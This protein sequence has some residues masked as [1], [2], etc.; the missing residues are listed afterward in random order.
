MADI[1]LLV[2]RQVTDL[3]AFLYTN[4]IKEDVHH[5]SILDAQGVIDLEIGESHSISLIEVKRMA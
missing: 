3:Y 4:L 5:I 1:G 2:D